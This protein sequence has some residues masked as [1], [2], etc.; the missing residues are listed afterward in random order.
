MVLHRCVWRMS[1]GKSK[2]PM[3]ERG[4][5]GVMISIS[6][7]L[8]GTLHTIFSHF[9]I[10]I[11]LQHAPLHPVILHALWCNSI[12]IFADLF[13]VYALIVRL[14]VSI[15]VLIICSPTLF[16]SPASCLLFRYTLLVFLFHCLVCCIDTVDDPLFGFR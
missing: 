1:V 13:T 2:K 10:I 5:V 15:V 3:C 4:S 11:Y 7:L 9:F 6:G 12:Y 16:S 14:H 8:S